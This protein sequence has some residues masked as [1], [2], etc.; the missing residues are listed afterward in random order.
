MADQDTRLTSQTAQSDLEAA[1]TGA[2]ARSIVGE[3]E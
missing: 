1:D 2:K 3:G